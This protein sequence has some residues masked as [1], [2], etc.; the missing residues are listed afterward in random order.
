M[1]QQD[2]EQEMRDLGISRYWKTV[3][4]TKERELETNSPLGR[5]LL[6]ES[7]G[8]LAD[9][10]KNW[11][12]QV[13]QK[14]AAQRSSAFPY[15]D[16]LSPLL[17]AAITARTVIDSISVHR[18]I[19]KTASTVA[20]MLE[21]EVRWREYRD[22]YP[23]L[24]RHTEGQIKKISGYETKRRY[25][26]NSEVYVDLQFDKWSP[27]IKVKVGM[28]LLELMRVATGIIDITTRTGMMGKRETYVHPTD[29]LVQW[30]KNAHNYA[31]DLSPLYLPMIEAPVPW[32]G[33]YVGGYKTEH[34]A[35]RPLIKTQDRAHLDDLNA[36]G[37]P[38]PIGA[39]NHLQNTQ[40]DINTFTFDTMKYCWENDIEVG[41]LPTADGDPIPSKPA[42]IDTNKEARRKWR[43][44]AAGVRFANEA[45]ASRRLQV[46]KVL[47]TADK[48]RD[49]KLWFSWYMCFRSRM[50]P[51]PAPMTP[52][53]PDVSRNL[54]RFGRG[55]V[56]ETEEHEFCLA[57]QGA[58]AFGED[59]CSLEDRVAWTYENEDIIKA[60]AE[61]PRGTTNLWG[62]AD[63]PWGFL[64]FCDEWARYLKEGKGFTT[65][66]PCGIDG[67]S[68]GLQLYSLL[69]LDPVGAAA[70]NV[71]PCDK[72]A[73]IY[74]D[75]SDKTKRLLEA[76]DHPY[77]KIWLKFGFDRTLSKR[78]CMVVPY[79]GTL[80]A[81]QNYV[82]EW[83]KD[84]IKKRK[85]VNPFGWEELYAPCAFI[86]EKIWEAIGEVVG[87]ARKAMSWFQDCSDIMIEQGLP[88][89][90][91]TPTGFWVKQAYE[92]WQRHS[93]RT[94]IGDVIRQHRIRVGTGTLDRRKARNAIAPNFIHSLDGSIGQLT[95]LDMFFLN[96][97]VFNLIHDEYQTTATHIPTMRD[98]LLNNV[99]K[100]F[101]V[102]LLAKFYKELHTY[103]PNDI[104]LPEPPERGDLDINCVRDSLYFFS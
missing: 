61:D 45:N 27:S 79:S 11:K 91:S 104:I 31:E 36:M 58:K 93:I 14:P 40:W 3:E 64:S 2:L 23:D 21:D 6:T 34:V 7:V 88:I 63:K 69:M 89:R 102:D 50:Y 86:S 77:A 66:L 71:M 76:S 99:V 10:I 35:Q 52:Q 12:R 98:C 15:I 92:T 41:D 51:K 100:V 5:R 43:K 57:A 54:L 67:A 60:V 28:V 44:L 95:S 80:Y 1:R 55:T 13:S 84:E 18:K 9:E 19:T 48:F 72:P 56:M 8:L 74:G 22:K 65:K 53:G 39:I 38:E 49:H 42:D 75:V 82:I 62:K 101:E 16:M 20:R 32:D 96:I 97:E 78:P 59:K 103:L 68:N 26:R 83:F 70:T 37:I 87:E 73:D 81:V 30:I 85:V 33:V 25:I 46:S 29:E 47:W 17:V 4:R 90:W 94:I 24:W